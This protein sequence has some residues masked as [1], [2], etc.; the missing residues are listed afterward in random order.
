MGGS[1]FQKRG[2]R[3]LKAADQITRILLKPSARLGGDA[4]LQ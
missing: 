1:S 4:V 3:L 2:Q